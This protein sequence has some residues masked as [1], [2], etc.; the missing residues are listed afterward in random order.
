MSY[1][2][3]L[4]SF[5]LIYVVMVSKK[6]EHS[7]EMR[8]LV[9]KHYQNGDSQREIAAK[10]FLPRETIPTNYSKVQGRSAKICFRSQR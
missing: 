4:S 6:K 10:T 7:N 1:I 5:T 8:T 2:D 9:I 3:H